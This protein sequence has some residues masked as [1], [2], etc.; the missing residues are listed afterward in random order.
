MNLMFKKL[1][2]NLIFLPLYTMVKL[3]QLT[4]TLREQFGF[5]RCRFYPSCSD[6]MLEAIQKHGLVKGVVLS[7]KRIV[8]C[9]PICEGGIDEV[10][11]NFRFL[12]VS[13]LCD[14][15]TQKASEER[16]ELSVRAKRAI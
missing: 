15:F 3:W 4:R 13:F 2:F 1:I 6:Y 5:V 16:S 7:V 12:K 14:L 10:P 11:N 8:R 9:N